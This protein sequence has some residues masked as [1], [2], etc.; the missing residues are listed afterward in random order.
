MTVSF[1]ASRDAVAS[2][3][4]IIGA[5]FKK[6]AFLKY[7]WWVFLAGFACSTVYLVARG[8]AAGRVPM[9]NQFEFSAMFAWG[10]A[11][12]LIILK[13]KDFV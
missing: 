2:S 10:I 3:R 13:E 4:R 8:I 6:E 9:S 12:I 5:S 7:A 1:S 11:L